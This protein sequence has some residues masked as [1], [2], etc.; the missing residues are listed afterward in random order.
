MSAGRIN[1][2]KTLKDSY[3]HY[4]E[5]IPESSLF[6]VDYK[7]YRKMCEEFNKK[8][9]KYI[10]EEAGEYTLPY[11]M[12]SIRI[13]KTKMDYNI[14]HMRPNWKKSKELGK[15]VYHVNDHTDGY[16]YRWAWNKSNVV[17]VGKKLYCFYPTR[18]NKRTLAS[19]LKDKDN[20]VDYFE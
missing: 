9:C 3:N 7:T 8:I 16:R 6:R 19:L 20:Y 5:E 1:G 2:A 14:N 15:R 4:I 18:T 12:G 10:L 13:K 11:R 17:T